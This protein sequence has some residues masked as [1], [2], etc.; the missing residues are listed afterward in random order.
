MGRSSFSL[1]ALLMLSVA[2][3]SGITLK[4][5]AERKR[6]PDFE[7][8]NGEGKI[9]RL[10]DYKGKVVLIDFWATWC[11]PCKAEIPWLIEMS[12][13]YEADGL[14]VLGISMDSEGWPVVKPFMEK[15]SITY[16]ILMG[17]KRAA[18][19]YGDVDALPVAF[20][21]DREQRVAAIHSGAASRKQFEQAVMA[22]LGR[23]K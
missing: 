21:V 11:G 3:I 8:K 13:K 5:E 15:M 22:L 10:S 17:T 14:V 12:K 16:P 4:K 2:T 23:S 18:Y 9:V 6:A 1:A 20:F 7:L 19:L